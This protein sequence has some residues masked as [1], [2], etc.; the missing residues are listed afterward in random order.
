MATLHFKV[1]GPGITKLVREMFLY[2][3]KEKALNI[4]T[5][6]GDLKISYAMN[7][8][9]GDAEFQNSKKDDG[10]LNYVKKEDLNWKNTIKEHKD[11]LIEEQRQKQIAEKELLEN[12][13]CD[14]DDDEYDD[15]FNDSDDF[16]EKLMKDTNKNIATQLFIQSVKEKDPTQKQVSLDLAKKYIQ[17]EYS[18]IFKEH[19]YTF[20]DSARNQSKCP[21]CDYSSKSDCWQKDDDGYIGCKNFNN[22]ILALC[23]ECPNCHENFYFHGYEK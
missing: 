9:N 6:L 11:F 15:D 4:I 3:D 8:L 19:E 17:K 13:D 18:F 16:L 10:T 12:L 7:V 1:D 2:G 5:T 21:H 22:G 14:Y 20:N 23:F